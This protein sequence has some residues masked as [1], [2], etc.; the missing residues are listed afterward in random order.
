MLAREIERKKSDQLPRVPG[1]KENFVYRDAW[2]RL[3][4]KPAKIMQVLTLPCQ[5]LLGVI[6]QQEYVISELQEYASELLAT[7]KERV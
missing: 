2:T 3:N 4:V 7:E 1:L 6:L 5:L